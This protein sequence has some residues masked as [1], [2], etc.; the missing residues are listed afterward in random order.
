MTKLYITLMLFLAC[1][2]SAGASDEGNTDWGKE[3]TRAC[4]SLIKNFWGASF[5]DSQ[6]QHYFNAYGDQASMR[7]E[8][9]WQAHAMDVVIDEYKRTGN[10]RC[11]QM[12][13]DWYEGMKGVNYEH[14]DDDPL[15]N[16][17]IDD[18]EWLCITMIRMYETCGEQRYFDHA[19]RLYDRYI[20]TSWGPE[21]EAPWYGGISWTWK[22]SVRKTKNA[23]SN[24]PGGIIAYML[25]RNLKGA[26]HDK[27]IDD[28]KKI[29]A[30]ERKVLFNEET[31]AVSD[32]MGY[33]GV[34]DG[35]FS[36]N[37]ATFI[38]MAREMYVQTKEAMY[39]EDAQKAVEFTMR[40][41][42]YGKTGLMAQISD[43]EWGGDHGLFHGIF[44]RYLT[45]LIQ[46]HVLSPEVE[47]RYVD[48]LQRMGELGRSNLVE[49]VGLFSRDWDN[50]RIT[51]PKDAPLT[52]HVAGATLMQMLAIAPL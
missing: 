33:G 6:G 9:W 45:E 13:D 26:E 25:A 19:R 22:A 30:W 29:Y 41:F 39:L 27:Y 17:S 40:H 8:W 47:K 12:Y 44:F 51:H 50:I 5:P 14:F 15:H 36:Y 16:N 7:S 24:G 3:A 20:I 23:C 18:M 2:L 1:S 43:Q 10:E 52:P 38:A 46:A 42:A 49:G 28:L 31:G 11:L 4:R 37:P 48:Y 21:D 35:Y 34:W 32:H